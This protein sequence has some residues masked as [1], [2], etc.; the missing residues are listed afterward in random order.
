[1]PLVLPAR[2]EGPRLPVLIRHGPL[3]R[4]SSTP[5]RTTAGALVPPSGSFPDDVARVAQIPFIAVRVEGPSLKTGPREA[6]MQ[7]P[8]TAPL[9]L[10]IAVVEAGTPAAHQRV[11]FVDDGASGA[12]GP[13]GAH[14][15]SDG[16]DGSRV[17]ETADVP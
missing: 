7:V 12:I 9:A 8:D 2:P 17:A 1:M 10:A 14:P 6:S 11:G 3:T 13:A 5:L 15:V 4:C 16:A